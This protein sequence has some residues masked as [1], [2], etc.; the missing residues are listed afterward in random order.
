MKPSFKVLVF[1]VH[2]A[3]PLFAL[4]GHAFTTSGNEAIVQLK[5]RNGGV[6]TCAIPVHF[7]ESRNLQLEKDRGDEAKLCRMA[8]SSD[9]TVVVQEKTPGKLKLPAEAKEFAVCPKLN[10]T[11]PGTNFIKIPKGWTREQTEATLCE[12]ESKLSVANQDLLEVEAKFK[13]SITCSYTPSALAGYHVSRL[14]GG[15]GRVPVAVLRTM[16]RDHHMA[17]V[18][19]AESALGHTREIISI[20]WQQF[21]KADVAAAAGQSNSKIYVENGSLLY[22]GLQKNLKGE[23][24]YSEISGGGSYDTRYE[25]FI[26]QPPFKRVTDERSVEQAAV[27]KSFAETYPTLNQMKDVSDMVLFDVLLSQDDRVGNIHY[28]V[29]VREIPSAGGAPVA[30][31]MSEVEE[32]ELD[33]VLKAARSEKVTESQLAQLSKRLFPAGNAI[34]VRA[35]YLKDNDCGVDVDKREN[36]MRSV[37]ALEKVRH[38][39][40]ET[41]A[42][43]LR[44]ADDVMSDR[45]K[46]FAQETL[47]YRSKDYEGGSKSLK[48]NVKYAL[49]TLKE[50]CRSGALKLD[51][52][53]TYSD[54]G[55]AQ[56]ANPV[57][58]E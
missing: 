29:E 14:L 55:L 53:V 27:G 25:R 8:L 16:D 30:R 2:V 5:G 39:S 57:A 43:F 34:L 48:E 20:A 45:F 3:V 23:E 54:G 32:A 10:S 4:Q 33:A 22:G 37:K 13:S 15:V 35:M 24:K 12:K 52:D 58:C 38:M 19:K 1:G 42:R 31:K 6:E 51:L 46:T 17:V 21:E 36:K 49:K 28:K 50:N 44:L 18:E 7:D 56:A 26:V 41:Y 9:G 47:L 40:G 11:N